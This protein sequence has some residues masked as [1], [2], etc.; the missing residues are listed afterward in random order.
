MQRLEARVAA[1]EATNAKAE[2]VT[3][4]RRMLTAGNAN[5]G[6]HYLS[7]DDGVRWTLQS[8]ETEQELIDRASREVKRNRWGFACL[9]GECGSGDTC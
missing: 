1:L 7:H 8:G 9:V 4:I 2:F 5:A 3:V 6:I